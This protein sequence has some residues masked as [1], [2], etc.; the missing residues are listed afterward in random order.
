MEFMEANDGYRK[1]C[2]SIIVSYGEL[3]TIT[4]EDYAMGNITSAD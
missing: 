2:D 3:K 1:I 4:N